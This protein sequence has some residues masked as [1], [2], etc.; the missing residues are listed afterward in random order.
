[1][2]EAETYSFGICCQRYD[3]IGGALCRAIANQNAAGQDRIYA[4]NQVGQ[5][6]SYGDSGT[7]G[8][9]SNPVEVGFGGWLP[10]QFLFCGANAAGQN[11]MYV[12]AAQRSLQTLKPA[13]A[14]GAS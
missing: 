5:L 3:T 10:F 1:L 7:P 11:R 8:N 9:V 14:G 13:L 12:V 4:V 6:L 2:I